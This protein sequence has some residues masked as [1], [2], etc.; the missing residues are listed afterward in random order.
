MAATCVSTASLPA[1]F[2][3]LIQASGMG[4]S[5]RVLDLGCGNGMIAEYLSDQ[6]GAHVTGIDFIPKAIQDARARTRST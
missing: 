2:D 3:H 4:P 5:S 1:V 6:S